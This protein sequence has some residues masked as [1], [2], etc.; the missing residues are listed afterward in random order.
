MSEI[1]AQLDV[2]DW[3]SPEDRMLAERDAALYGNAFIK[4]GDDGLVRRVDP[5]TVQPYIGVN[6]HKRAD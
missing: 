5:T 3:A 4:R 1:G 6:G 2:F